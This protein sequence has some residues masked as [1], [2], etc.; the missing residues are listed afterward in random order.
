MTNLGYQELAIKPGA[1]HSKISYALEIAP[2]LGISVDSA[3][4][5]VENFENIIP[6]HLLENLQKYGASTQLISRVK[7]CLERQHNIIWEQ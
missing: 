1:H 5:I 7:Q 2:L 4:G 6:L 3:K